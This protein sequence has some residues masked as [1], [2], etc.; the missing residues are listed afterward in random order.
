M[1]VGFD[2]PQEDEFALMNLG[3]GSPY[4]EWAFPNRRFYTEWLTL[5]EVTPDER[6]RWAEWF[7][8]FMR[9]L[10][11]RK[12]GARIVMKSPGHTARVKLLLEMY[13]EARFIHIVRDPRV[14]VPSAVRTWSR[15]MDATSLQIR[16]DR[17]LEDHIFDMFRL[18]YERFEQDKALIPENQFYQLRYE[19]L[20]A[21]PIGELEAIY[22]KLDLGDFEVARPAVAKYLEGVKNYR[23][24][25]Y[26]L[27]PELADKIAARC[28]DYMRRYGYEAAGV[29]AASP[30]ATP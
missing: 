21:N 30:T 6:K 25:K 15:M 19:D 18:M 9:R 10:S 17:P 26:E 2:R 28:G 20:V 22:S 11:L 4:L 7:D 5:D 23:T 1:A 12:P 3:A 8:W 27:E 24:N 29:G 14:V 13:P 16:G